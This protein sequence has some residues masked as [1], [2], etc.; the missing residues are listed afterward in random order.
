MTPRHQVT[1]MKHSR[2]ASFDTGGSAEGGPRHPSS[3]LGDPMMW[4]SPSSWTVPSR[5]Y[6]YRTVS[7]SFSDPRM[8]GILRKPIKVHLCL[9]LFAWPSSC[10]T[11][12]PLAPYQAVQAH[13][14]FLMQ[15][16]LT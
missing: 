11:A 8:P 15:H 3:M 4:P 2:S 1:G 14:P 5:T 9:R 16:L 13:V 6:E 12:Q 10:K 7:F